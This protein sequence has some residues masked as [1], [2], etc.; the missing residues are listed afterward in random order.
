MPPASRIVV[1]M[2]VLVGLAG[3]PGPDE[4]DV[5]WRDAAPVRF[6]DASPDDTL[7]AAPPDAAPGTCVRAH[8][9]LVALA[10]TPQA[11]S[12]DT[13][14]PRGSHCDAAVGTCA[15]AC[16]SSAGCGAGATCSC[17]GFCRPEGS[18]AGD[19]PGCGEGDLRRAPPALDV[20]G[21]HA[22]PID[23]QRLDA[24]V[25]IDAAARTASADAVLDFVLGPG[26]GG[27]AI[28]DLRQTILRARLNGVDI[29]VDALAAHDLGGGPGAEMR[30]LAIPLPACSENRLV[31]S[32]ALEQP[33]SPAAIPI[34]FSP[35]RPRLAWDLWLSDLYPGRYLESWF[36]ANL[37]YDRFA[38]ALDLAITGAEGAHVPISN[39]AITTLA[40][41]HWKI[42]FPPSSTAFSPMLSLGPA[43]SLR[44]LATSLA[45]VDGT[46]VELALFVNAAVSADLA[47]VAAEIQGYLNDFIASTGPY[48]HGDRL[49]VY[50]WN[51]DERS[52]EYDG[53]TTSNL[54]SLEHELF[55]SWY[56]RGL[57]PASQNDGWIDEAWDVFNTGELAFEP[58]ALADDAPA[59]TLS[60]ADPWVRVT[61]YLAYSSGR[62][63]F[64]HIASLVGVEALRAA[65]KSFYA[66][67]IDAQLVSTAELAQHIYCAT[68]EARVLAAFHRFA[69]GRSDAPP[70]PPPCP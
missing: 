63:L 42:A 54:S 49:T 65:M 64:A 32:Y 10:A 31:V 34:A 70:A 29:P 58:I 21:L 6:A 11:C 40:P 57:K 68:G 69:F 13:E 15:F 44:Q 43:D 18:P 67:H 45:L 23:V 50:I 7:D 20:D 28:F 55:H 56:G 51:V 26:P 47:T 37:I 4:D 5:D 17:D 24:R 36:P 2:L 33:A 52:M 39:G 53:A 14:C 60:S 46:T 3:C 48:A 30:V 8:E 66:L 35:T 9:A 27:H 41:A 22:V 12:V 38:F 1:A 16:E 25:V 61:P 62:Q 19:E 59:V